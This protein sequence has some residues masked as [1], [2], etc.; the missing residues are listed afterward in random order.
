MSGGRQKHEHCRL[1]D[2]D[3]IEKCKEICDIE[4]CCKGY[5]HN[6]E[7][8]KCLIY[9]ASDCNINCYKRNQGSNKMIIAGRDRTS[10]ESGCFVKNIGL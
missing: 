4:E 8:K 5:S 3:E 2:I 6:P 1:S 9:T 10:K 7:F